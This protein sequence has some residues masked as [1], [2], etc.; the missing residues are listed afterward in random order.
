MSDNPAVLAR[1]FRGES[2]EAVHYGSVAVVNSDGRLTH[3]AGDPHFV[4]MMRS[5]IKPFQLMPLL[6]SGAADHFRFSSRQLAIMCGSHNG[7]DAHREVVAGNLESAGLDSS[8]LLCGA[9][10]PLGK[11]EQE[12]FPDRD[13]D[14]DPLRHNCSGKHSGFLALA[15]FLG[16]PLEDYLNPESKSQRLVKRAL[17]EICE[18]DPDKMPAG[19]DG[20]SAPNYPMPIFNLALGF[21]KLANLDAD[22]PDMMRILGQIKGAMSEHPEMVSGEKRLDFDLARSFPGNLI[23]KIGAES[24]EGIGMSD[25]AVGI[26]VKIHDGSWRALGAVCVAVLR[27]LNIIRDMDDVPL[28][29]RHDSPPVRSDRNIITGRV[30]A[31]VNLI[32][33]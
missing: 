23:C 32:E 24:I 14:K 1:V 10:W 22:N 12:I 27:Q 5:S 15:K 16:D 4:T 13:E 7:T 21:K 9:H 30:L 6:T 20:C 2:V 29:K 18:Y 28:L 26:A 33:A 3:Y 8:H 11:K 17:A 25:P 19:I 31:E